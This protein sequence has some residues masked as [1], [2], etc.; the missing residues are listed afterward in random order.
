MPIST[1]SAASS[2]SKSTTLPFSYTMG[3]SF[4]WCFLGDPRTA[5]VAFWLSF[6]VLGP[7]L[8][9]IGLDL[10]DLCNLGTSVGISTLT[11]F[12]APPLDAVGLQNSPYSHSII[13]QY[14]HILPSCHL[15]STSTSLHLPHYWVITMLFQSLLILNILK[16]IYG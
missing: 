5:C 2:D 14:L 3:F 7:S 4:F 11:N 13:H 12:G 8:G 6:F 15:H 1:F 10:G 16:W 9:S